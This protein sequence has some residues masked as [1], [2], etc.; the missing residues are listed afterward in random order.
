ML[1]PLPHASLLAQ[2]RE[3]QFKGY[4]PI[5]SEPICPICPIN[6][7]DPINPVG[8]VE[9]KG[10]E[11]KDKDKDKDSNASERRDWSTRGAEDVHLIAHPN[12]PPNAAV[13][14]INTHTPISDNNEDDETELKRVGQKWSHFFKTSASEAAILMHNLRV[15]MN[16]SEVYQDNQQIEQIEL[17]ESPQKARHRHQHQQFIP[18]HHKEGE[19]PLSPYLGQL[20]SKGPGLVYVHDCYDYV[21]DY[22]HNYDTNTGSYCYCY[23]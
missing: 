17:Q 6:P 18:R 23:Y 10:V 3:E 16:E 7:I 8:Q 2:S 20:V 14:S 1:L 4:G 19:S 13:D 21:H 9:K 5:F 12:R 22:L 15:Q 11:G